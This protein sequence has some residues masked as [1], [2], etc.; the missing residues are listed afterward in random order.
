MAV[1]DV[2]GRGAATA[3][4]GVPLNQALAGDLDPDPVQLARGD[5]VPDDLE[6]AA[7]DVEPERS[8]SAV[9]VEGV[10][11]DRHPDGPVGLEAAREPVTE[12]GIGGVALDRRIEDLHRRGV[13]GL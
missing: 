1:E 10:P 11:D 3:R 5:R 13:V 12:G 6:V 7:V 4:H 2:D 8:P 9:V